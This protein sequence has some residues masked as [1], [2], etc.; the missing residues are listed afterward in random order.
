[1]FDADMVNQL[2]GAIHKAIEINHANSGRP[3]PQN[4]TTCLCNGFGQIERNEP[5]VLKFFALH[6]DMR[7][8]YGLG[9]RTNGAHGDAWA[10]STN[11]PMAFMALTTATPAS[12]SFPCTG[13]LVM[14][15]PNSLLR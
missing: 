11:M 9:R 13:A 12:L 1:M 7:C 6:V 14:M 2:K 4:A 3:R 5:W 10:T 15:S 8:N